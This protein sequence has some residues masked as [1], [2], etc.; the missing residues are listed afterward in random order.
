MSL[1]KSLLMLLLICVG[2]GFL[3]REIERD[4]AA[5]IEAA[6]KELP[7]R[8]LP[9]LIPDEISRVSVIAPL[10]RYSL[11]HPKDLTRIKNVESPESEWVLADPAGAQIDPEKAKEILSALDGLVARNTL[12]EADLSERSNFGLEPPEM[13]I[14]F[15]GK[16]LSQAISLGKM[17]PVTRRRYAQKEEDRRVFLVDSEVFESLNIAKDELRDRHP[18]KRYQDELIGL[19]LARPSGEI[20]QFSMDEK[21]KDWSA[22]TPTATIPL[23]DELFKERLRMMMHATV[24]E[25][26]D[27]GGAAGDSYGLA[28]PTLTISLERS[29]GKPVRKIDVAEVLGQRGKVIYFRFQDDPFI[30]RARG[31]FFADFVRSL[32]TFR[33]R[34]FLQ[35]VEE[36]NFISLQLLRE[37]K[38]ITEI[39][40]EQW[41]E[42]KNAEL[43]RLLLDMVVLHFDSLENDT[44]RMAGLEN[45]RNE[46]D[47]EY[48]PKEGESPQKMRILLGNS[49]VQIAPT[50]NESPST[51]ST[52]PDGKPRWLGIQGSDGV[53]RPAVLGGV[54]AEKLATLLKEIL[55]LTQAP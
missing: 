52:R 40:G 41:K 17:H 43:R 44:L 6:Q 8:L 30:Y 23:D 20:V 32:E 31:V 48:I 1:R 50:P 42:S 25:F 53:L 10:G 49:I 5:S 11:I 7:E 21:T 15:S 29:G 19:R 18:L 34:H 33:N 36:Q 47:F 37:G 54:P 27:Q 16:S 13:T 3:F 2:G 45:S 9:K 22:K 38:I 24:E 12:S 39:R 28:V 35:G 4:E 26:I 46:I 51:A 55:E 14:V